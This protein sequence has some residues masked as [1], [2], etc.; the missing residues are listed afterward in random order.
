MAVTGISMLMILMLSLIN[1]LS[2]SMYVYFSN[3]RLQ[4]HLPPSRNCPES[5]TQGQLYKAHIDK[6]QFSKLTH[7]GMGCCKVARSGL[8]GQ[9]VAN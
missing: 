4:W 9:K 8:F 3:M 5:P 6:A 1:L 2:N 7:I